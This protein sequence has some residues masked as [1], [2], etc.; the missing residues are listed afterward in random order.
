MRF[1]EL[2]IVTRREMPAR[3]RTD[4]E[5]YLIRAGYVDSAGE[6]TRLGEHA[7][8]RLRTFM[9]ADPD[10][11]ALLGPNYMTVD[12]KTVTEASEGTSIY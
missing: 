11:W 3:A 12:G 5:R 10:R 1:N 6:P 4:G 7:I 8:A 2:G 9:T